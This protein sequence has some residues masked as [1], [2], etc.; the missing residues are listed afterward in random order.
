MT[1]FTYFH[2]LPPFHS[3]P[4][5]LQFTYPIQP[6]PSYIHRKHNL[7]DFQ[8]TH[9]FTITHIFY[10]P[11]YQH[12]KYPFQTSHHHFLFTFF[13]K[14]QKQPKT[15]IHLPLL[16]PPYHYIFKSSHLF[17]LFHPKPPISLTQTTPYISSITNMPRHLPNTF[18]H[19][20]QKL[21]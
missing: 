11:Q 14:Y 12:S 6:L 15:H 3:K 19:Q 17:N 13:T 1:H 9:P 20:T 2:H 18:Y 8:S 21:P 16:H 4:L 10:H 7:F 5:S